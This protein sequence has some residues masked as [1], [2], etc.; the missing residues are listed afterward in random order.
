MF[1]SLSCWAFETLAQCKKPCMLLF[2]GHLFVSRAFYLVQSLLS[3][4]PNNRHFSRCSLCTETNKHALEPH[5]TL[6]KIQKT[7]N[8]RLDRSC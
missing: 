5:I 2:W 4:K 7:P 8:P 3:S 6:V 1:F